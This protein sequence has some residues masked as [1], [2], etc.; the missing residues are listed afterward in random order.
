MILDPDNAPEDTPED[1]LTITEIGD[2]NWTVYMNGGLQSPSYS[3]P[4]A[5]LQHADKLRW[6]FPGSVI[7]IK[8]AATYR[9]E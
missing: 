4:F 2:T 8:H 1:A 9:I 7:E 5:A 6:D 3:E